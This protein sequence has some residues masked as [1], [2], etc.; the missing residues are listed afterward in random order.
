[1]LII[2]KY[3]NRDTGIATICCHV[4]RGNKITKS[5]KPM[6]EDNLE[7]FKGN[8]K[9]AMINHVSQYNKLEKVEIIKDF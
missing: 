3:T 7:L 4:M 5:Y 2:N 1:M 9:H 6:P 8:Y